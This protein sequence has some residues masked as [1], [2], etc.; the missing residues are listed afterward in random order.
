MSVVS[1]LKIIKSGYLY[2]YQKVRYGG[3]KYSNTIDFVDRNR[4]VLASNK[5]PFIVVDI[6]KMLFFIL[7]W[8]TFS[9]LL[10]L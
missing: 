6:L 3:L 10:T 4:E 8:Y 9:I 2:R 7:V 1:L 5:S